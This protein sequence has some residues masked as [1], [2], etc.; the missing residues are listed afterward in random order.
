MFV[1]QHLTEHPVHV[2]GG[3]QKGFCSRSTLFTQ[4]T[5][6]I[7]FVCT[8]T[9]V[10]CVALW[11]LLLMLHTHSLILCENIHHTKLYPIKIYTP[12]SGV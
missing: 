2:R 12:I 5:P 1:E 3:E 7:A 8:R 6:K 9:S 11:V 10:W 4:F